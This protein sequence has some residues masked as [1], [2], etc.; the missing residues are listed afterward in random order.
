MSDFYWEDE[1]GFYADMDYEAHLQMTMTEEEYEKHIRSEKLDALR[2][3]RLLNQKG[4]FLIQAKK[5][6]KVIYLQDQ[7]ISKGGYWT[8]FKSNARVFTDKVEAQNLAKTFKYNNP[9]VVN[10]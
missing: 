2:N 6:G 4:K 10:G 3:L 7:K 9:I 1:G 8:Q 5:N